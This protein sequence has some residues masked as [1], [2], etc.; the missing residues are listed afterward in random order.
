VHSVNWY[1]IVKWCNARSEM[2][3]LTPCYTV[4]NATY[5]T[6]SS[7]PTCNWG[8]NGYRLPTEAEWEKAARGGVSGMNFPWG[9]DTISLLQA[10]FWNFGGEPYQTG[11]TGRHPIHGVDPKPWTSP[12]GSFAPNGY[13]LYDMAGNVFEWCWDRYAFNYYASSPSTDPRG[14]S[15]GT[16]RMARGGYWGNSAVFCRVAYRIW[17]LPG[18]SGDGRGF[19]LARGSAP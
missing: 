8:A 11:T 4:S 16:S 17:Y 5:K 2:E 18:E 15:T 3:G 19:R 1:D 14:S 13:S 9:T 10:N 7:N 6:G 12:V